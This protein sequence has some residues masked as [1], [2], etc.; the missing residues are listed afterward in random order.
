MRCGLLLPVL[1]VVSLS[2]AAVQGAGHGAKAASHGATAPLT[3]MK[4]DDT[5][6]MHPNKVG[7]AARHRE[8]PGTPSGDPHS[9]GLRDEAGRH[10]DGGGTK[11]EAMTHGRHCGPDT[12][13]ACHTKHNCVRHKTFCTWHAID[14][15]KGM[16]A[17]S[18]LCL[19]KKEE[20]E[21]GYGTHSTDP[22]GE[23]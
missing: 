17:T 18:G 5:P 23:L 3:P 10:L 13:H 19:T 15:H 20:G 6:A 2:L 14:H 9:G 12:C 4:S 16:H 7:Y 8:H 21:I 22:H 1:F 11:E